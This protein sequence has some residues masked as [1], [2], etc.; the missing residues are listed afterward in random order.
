MIQ[1]NKKREYGKEKTSEKKKRRIEWYHYLIWVLGII[2]LGLLLF[3]II[4]N[5]IN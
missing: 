2:A 1:D 4:R 5:L 3:G